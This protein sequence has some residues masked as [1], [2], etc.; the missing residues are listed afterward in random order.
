[1]R[2]FAGFCERRGLD[3]PEVAAYLDYLWRFIA[4]SGSTEAFGRW[5]EEEPPLVGSGLGWEY[6]PGF[7]SFLAARGAAEGEFRRALCC[8]TEVLFGS[9]Y[10]A[11]DES[12]SRR[13][14]GELAGLVE[15]LGV[16]FPDTRQFARSRWADG[17]GWGSDL[18]AEELAAWRCA[19]AAEPSAAD[20]TMKVKPRPR[21]DGR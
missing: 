16:S 6:P 20:V 8:T 5:A 18:S 4:L 1:M 13:F 15:P 11:A 7:E 19:G 14:V 12:G 3:H 2:L 17:W 10:G 21:D 9:L